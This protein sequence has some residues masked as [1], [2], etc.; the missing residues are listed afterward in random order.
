MDVFILSDA[1][2]LVPT[3]QQT[4]TGWQRDTEP[5][6]LSG[7]SYTVQRYRPRIEGLFARIERWRSDAT[8]DTFWKT[9]SKDNVTSIFGSDSASRIAN[10]DDPSEVFSWLLALSYDDRGNA[11]LY[12]YKPEDN[13]NVPDAL[14]EQHREVAAKRYLKTILYGNRTPFV[15]ADGTD[16]PT[17]W[18]FEAV[19]DYGEHDPN[20]P[21]PTEVMPWRCRPD[22]FS[23]YRS[24]FEVRT[25]RL[26]SRVLMFHNF[27]DDLPLP[28]FPNAVPLP[29]YLVRSTDFYYSCDDTP[30]DPLSPNYTYLE[31]AC[32]SGYVWQTSATGGA[33]LQR[34]IPSLDFAYTKTVIDPTLREA[35]PSVL[36][37]LPAGVDG[38]RYQWV[39]LDSEGSPG[40]L[41]Q[42]ELRL[43]L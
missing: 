26:C 15:P 9:I 3:L 36:E 11:I 2:D 17:D 1:E 34:S 37:N 23:T 16:L 10:P 27:P 4:G 38:A 6:D 31:S 39:D 41:S 33:Y 40:V 18:C 24:C 28:N 32:Q 5:G 29:N 12:R 19:L 8:G 25:Y 43:V 14:H 13:S 22:P 20:T 21:T 42:Q 35:D 30:P 7:Q